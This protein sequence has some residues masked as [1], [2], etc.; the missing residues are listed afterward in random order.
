M[1]EPATIEVGEIAGDGL[2]L[3]C[4]REAM[5]QGEVRLAAQ[6]SNRTALESRATSIL[7]WSVAATVA[8]GLGVLRTATPAPP[9]PM[10]V[11][12]MHLAPIGTLCIAA[13]FCV[14]ALWP[15]VWI[16]AGHSLTQIGGLGAS[17]ELQICEALGATYETGFALNNAA[18]ARMSL[19]LKCAWLW[20]LLTIPTAA[21]SAM[22]G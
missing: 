15:T 19:W 14:R 18:L 22:V 12:G 8:L 16:S 5:R 9:T 1:D 21:A 7:A 4:A 2:R 3:W 11:Q 13:V 10:W 17:T 20:L 6:T